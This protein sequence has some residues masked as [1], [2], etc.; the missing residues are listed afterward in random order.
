MAKTTPLSQVNALK[1]RQWLGD[2]DEV[3]WSKVQRR[4]EPPH[5]FYQFSIPRYSQ[6]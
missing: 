6:K 1:V 2:W 3:R 5:W 4:A